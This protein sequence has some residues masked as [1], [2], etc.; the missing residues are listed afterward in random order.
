MKKADASG[1]EY[2]VIIGEAELAAG[3]ATV[4]AL[5]GGGAAAPFAQQQTLALAELGE[6]LVAAMAAVGGMEDEPISGMN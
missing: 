1:A 2:A 5:R 3:I 4:K 6:A